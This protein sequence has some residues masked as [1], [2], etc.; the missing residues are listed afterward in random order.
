MLMLC[1]CHCPQSVVGRYP[2]SSGSSVMLW[3]TS[4]TRDRARQEPPVGARCPVTPVHGMISGYDYDYDNIKMY[5]YVYICYY[6]SLPL[7]SE[8]ATSK[9][10]LLLSVLAERFGLYST[11]ASL[12]PGWWPCQIQ[13]LSQK[14]TSGR[15]VPSQNCTFCAPK[16]PFLAQNGP[17]TQ[18]ERPNEGKR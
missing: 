9:Q 15:E 10:A 2:R 6:T 4:G 13:L 14:L 11:V 12:E 3:A 7:S 5:V 16:Q 1:S 8:Q 18:S 17:E